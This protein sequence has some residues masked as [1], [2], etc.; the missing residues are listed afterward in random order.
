MLNTFKNS[1]NVSF[2]TSANMVIYFLKRLPLIGKK[3][4]QS[5]YKKTNIK[6][7]LGFIGLI[8]EIS[9][10]FLIKGIYILLAIWL[11]AMAITE[12]LFNNNVEQKEI[13]LQLFFILSFLLGSFFRS[14]IFNKNHESYK[15]IKLMRANPKE[16]YFGQ[17]IYKIITQFIYFLPALVIS[18]IGFLNSIILLIE[19]SAFRIFGE[20]ANLLLYK[21]FK[22]VLWKNIGISVLLAI[23]IPIIPALALNLGGTVKVSEILFN[24]IFL[25]CTLFIVILIYISIWKYKGYNSLSRKVLSVE[26]LNKKSQIKSDM[27]VADIKLDEKKMNESDLNSRKYNNKKGYDYLNSVFFFRHSKLVRTPILISVIIIVLVFIFSLI[28]ILI[29]FPDKK[30]ETINIIRGSAPF[31]ILLLYWL[32][33]TQK[34][35]KAMFFNCDISLLRYGF[36]KEGKGILNNF[37]SRLKKMISFNLIPAATMVVLLSIFIVIIG[38]FTALIS[39]IPILICIITL[40]LFFSI[41]SLFLYYMLQPYTAELTIKSPIFR[42][43]NTI[44]YIVCY[45]VSRIE[46]SS[47]YFTLVVIG[48]TVLFVPLSLFLVYQYAPKTF[49]LK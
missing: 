39:I 5:W 33:S 35:C 42:I 32:S 16:Y 13:F 11:P 21:K 36:Y 1:F 47:I 9:K 40:S 10:G 48:I 26:Y 44:L 43:S 15:M 38:G 12:N 14:V 46:T 17:I 6:L 28:G 20:W 27:L 37:K 29:F 41:Y 31:L 4:P 25:T 22:F 3:I 49:K 2:A 24:P 18:Q 7:I 23:L 45:N 34:L 19:L 8:F 30:L